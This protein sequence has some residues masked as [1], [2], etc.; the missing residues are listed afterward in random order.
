M[1]YISGENVPAILTGDAVIGD[2]G[3][4]LMADDALENVHAA[5]QVIPVHYEGRKNAERV[6]SSR[7]REQTFVPT[8]VD[9][10]IR[11]FD[12]V[13][14]PDVAG[15]TNGSHFSRASRD[16]VE[17]ITEPCSVFTNGP[18]QRWIRQPVD[19]IP[20]NSRHERPAAKGRSMISR[21]NCR[22][23]LLRHENCTNRQ[24][25]SQRLGKRQHIG[26][27]SDVLVC[28]KMSGTS[29]TAL[30]LVENESDL[31]LRGQS[32]KAA[33]KIGIEYA[34]S[35]FALDRLD[36]Q[37]RNRLSLE[38]GIEIAEVALTY[39]DPAGEWAKRCAIR[40]TIGSGER[41]EEPAVKAST[42][43]YDLDFCIG[44]GLSGPP[45]REL[46]RTFIRLRPRVAE[47]YLRRERPLNQLGG[48]LLTGRGSIEVRCVDQAGAQRLVYYLRN[49]R[50][51]ITE[52]IH[53]DPACKIE[54]ALAIGVDELYAISHHELHR[55]A[56]VGWKERR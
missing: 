11:R 49:S 52:R 42:Q 9:D 39:R 17:L 12:H 47:K 3:F 34:H 19:D 28:E 18:E 4:R 31:P 23:N 6:I 5:H 45:S 48:E 13:E 33:E 14:T 37:S 24:P 8:A 46:E 30:D 40:G 27:D 55:C 51:S 29:E 25:A 1:P 38:G 50:I 36:D 21:L 10:F 20:G 2:S 53:R 22:C 44:A 54:I 15:S 7:E 43:G 16:C 32:T 26:N 41:R 56:L 35:S